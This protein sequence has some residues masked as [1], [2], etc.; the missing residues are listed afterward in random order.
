MSCGLA[1]LAWN[2]EQAAMFVCVMV[3]G[4]IQI[5]EAGN[6]LT[7]KASL[8]AQAKATCG[9]LKKLYFVAQEVYF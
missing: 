7:I 2:P 3:D 5:L 8:T 6:N 1:D 9:M 4:S